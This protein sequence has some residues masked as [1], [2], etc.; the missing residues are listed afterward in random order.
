MSPCLALL[1]VLIPSR[2]VSVHTHT[3]MQ[4]VFAHFIRAGVGGLFDGRLL[5]RLHSGSRWRLL[6]RTEQRYLRDCCTWLCVTG[7][8]LCT[9]PKCV[10]GAYLCTWNPHP[11]ATS[12]TCS[13][14]CL[15]LH[16]C[17]RW[18]PQYHMGFFTLS[19]VWAAPVTHALSYHTLVVLACCLLLITV[20]SD[21]HLLLARRKRLHCHVTGRFWHH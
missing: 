20:I 3:H 8:Y 2:I 17:L 12:N 16:R 14:F 21:R 18:P 15:A 13:V 11:G 7:A 10:I 4:P 9:A 5:L 19:F 1:L 6:W